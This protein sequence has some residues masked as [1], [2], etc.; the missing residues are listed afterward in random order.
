MDGRLTGQTRRF[1]NL[2][3]HRLRDLA[4][5]ALRFL[6]LL[7]LQPFLFQLFLEGLVLQLA[8][9]FR[10]LHSRLSRNHPQRGHP[11]ML[12]G[13]VLAVSLIEHQ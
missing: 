8:K 12:F 2:V 11:H 7:L 13:F 5:H 1:C 10:L 3:S 4:W 6:L 9:S